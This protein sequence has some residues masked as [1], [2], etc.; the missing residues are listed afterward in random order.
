MRGFLFGTRPAGDAP[1]PDPGPADDRGSPPAA[2][3]TAAAAGSG[4]AAPAGRP[5]T[6]AL[7]LRD[8]ERETAVA[9]L[10]DAQHPQLVRLAALL[11]AGHEAEDVVAEAFCS[12]YR[13]WNRLRDGGAA[14][15]YLRS[16]VV[17]ETKMRLRH[18][19][20]V[21]RNAAPVSPPRRSAEA[22]VLVREVQREVQAA[23]DGLPTRQREAI[24]LRYWMD[25]READVAAAMGVS[26]GTVKT[27]TSRAMAA[28]AAR[29]EPRP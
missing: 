15:P 27:H 25:L 28:L 29:L 20:V 14:L 26:P 3:V 13:R 11:G 1:A 6:G 19:Q 9:R 12:L 18:R 2:L 22:E 8:L 4:T 24:V 7:D 17:N 10:F 16:C 21:A 23:L 5:P